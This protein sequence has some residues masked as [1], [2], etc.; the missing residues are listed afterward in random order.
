MDF[1][2]DQL[3]EAELERRARFGNSGARHLLRLA[4]EKRDPWAPVKYGYLS[5]L[6]SSPRPVGR[7]PERSLSCHCDGGAGRVPPCVRC[8][9]GDCDTSRRLRASAA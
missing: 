8:L 7:G 9:G 6:F 3:D 1:E 2:G 5:E 4:K